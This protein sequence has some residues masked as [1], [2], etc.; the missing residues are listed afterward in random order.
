MRFNLG[1]VGAVRLPRPI[2]GRL[3]AVEIEGV[4]LVLDGGVDVLGHIVVKEILVDAHQDHELA[5]RGD[6][7][8]VAF[9]VQG[10]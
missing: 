1:T 10:A 5:H 4:L 8:A 6:K 7:S 3:D 9:E 2:K